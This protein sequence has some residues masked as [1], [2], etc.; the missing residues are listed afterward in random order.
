MGIRALQWRSCTSTISQV[1]PAWQRVAAE[2]LSAARTAKALG[3]MPDHDRH[4]D[5]ASKRWRCRGPCGRSWTVRAH[6]KRAPCAKVE[7]VRK[8]AILSA[9]DEKF[10]REKKAE[11]A[12][13]EDSERHWLTS[14]GPPKTGGRAVRCDRCG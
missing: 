1:S 3:D 14:F 9:A 6:C 10:E 11:M 12:K 7:D 13:G 2:A 4:W 5:P 8:A